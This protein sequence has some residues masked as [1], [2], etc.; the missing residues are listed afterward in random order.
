MDFIYYKY[1]DFRIQIQAKI[2]PVLKMT[3][4]K[5]LQQC[6]PS[7]IKL[8]KA[9]KHGFAYIPQFLGYKYPHSPQSAE[10]NIILLWL[11]ITKSIRRVQIKC[12]VLHDIFTVL[13]IQ[14][15][16]Y[17]CSGMIYNSDQNFHCSGLRNINLQLLECSFH[18]FLPVTIDQLWEPSIILQKKNQLRKK[19]HG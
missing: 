14:T 6:K 13:S 7:F 5:S 19:W 12:P 9:I 10:V 4:R 3:I 16:S 15:L 11:I 2:F 17:V 8:N 18:H 1:Y